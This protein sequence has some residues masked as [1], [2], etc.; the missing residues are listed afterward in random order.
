MGQIQ[1]SIIIWKTVPHAYSKNKLWV[2]YTCAG[3]EEVVKHSYTIYQV[4]PLYFS[5]L[6]YKID[7]LMHVHGNISYI[8]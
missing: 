2:N 4:T 5:I 3:E 6:M 8:Y 1:R 7:L